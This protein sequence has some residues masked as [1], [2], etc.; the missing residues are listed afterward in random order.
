MKYLTIVS[1]ILALSAATPTASVA[2]CVNCQIQS[3]SPSASAPGKF[4]Y[5]ISCIDDSS[6]DE[7]NS[8]ITA[9]SDEEALKVMQSTKC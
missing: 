7:L 2:G 3:K 9:S 1:T 8:L 6:G 4:E 5:R